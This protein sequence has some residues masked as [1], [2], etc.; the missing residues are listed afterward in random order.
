MAHSASFGL[1]SGRIRIISGV[2]PQYTEPAFKKV[3]QSPD[4]MAAEQ[5]KSMRRA[6]WGLLLADI[7]YRQEQLRQIKSFNPWP[8]V[9]SGTNKAFLEQSLAAPRRPRHRTR[10]R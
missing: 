2:P 8:V 3:P 6:K 1:S 7:D 10:C 4:R 5:L 9:F